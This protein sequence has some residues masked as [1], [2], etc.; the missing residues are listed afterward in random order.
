MPLDENK[1]IEPQES[2]VNFRRSIES[3]MADHS[4]AGLTLAV[5]KHGELKIAEGYG[6]TDRKTKSPMQG[7]TLIRIASL[8]KPITAAVILR[9][10]ELELI[11]LDR[12]AFSYL[13]TDLRPK[14]GIQNPQLE[15]ITIRNLL[16][17]TGGWDRSVS[18]LRD[19]MFKNQ[20]IAKELG[21]S[22]PAQVEEIIRYM[23]DHPLDH[24]PG[25]KFAYSNLGY[26]ILGRI[27]ESVSA[28]SYEE[29][30]CHYVLGPAGVEA[31]EMGRTLPKDRPVNEANYHYWDPSEL[32]LSVF[33]AD[34]AEVSW[35]DG[36]FYLESMDAHGGWIANVLDLSRF[37]VALE[38]QGNTSALLDAHS[39]QHMTRRP[40]LEIHEKQNA[41]YG[42]GWRIRQKP[43]GV[44]WWHSG[45]LHGSL[46]LMTRSWDGYTWCVLLN[47][48]T[49]VPRQTL[50]GLDEMLGA[51][52]RRAF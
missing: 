10:S 13:P 35:P 38:G 47:S 45:Y 21:L 37:V 27:I 32:A 16:Q 5:T 18:P 9:M 24:C 50:D 20:Q 52:A 33:A 17:H 15:V 31:M 7:D 28:M 14:A 51:A 26:A 41:W 39:L 29:A 2:L 1:G 48:S 23:L 43:E 3:F 44:G 36:G 6:V 8:A 22:R 30:S 4:I 42:L 40:A 34:A 49:E 19:P 12:P 11:D 46:S 25:S